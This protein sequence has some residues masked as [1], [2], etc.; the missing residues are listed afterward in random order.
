MSLREV[1]EKNTLWG[2]QVDFEKARAEVMSRRLKDLKNKA[3]KL[4]LGH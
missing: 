4:K 3:P 2:N 1:V